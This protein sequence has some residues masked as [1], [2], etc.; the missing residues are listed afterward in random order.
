MHILVKETRQHS[1]VNFGGR[2]NKALLCTWRQA[3]FQKV[4]EAGEQEGMQLKDL[5][6][7]VVWKSLLK[8]VELS[9]EIVKQVFFHPS[10]PLAAGKQFVLQWVKTKH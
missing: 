2:T 8:G 5:L 3:M 4:R 6:A 7:G 10:L 9:W 1:H